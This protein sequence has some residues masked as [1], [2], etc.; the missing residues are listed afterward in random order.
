MIEIVEGVVPQS[1]DKSFVCKKSGKTLVIS[2]AQ[3]RPALSWATYHGGFR[4]QVSHI[5]LHALNSLPVQNAR[6]AAS[7][8]DLRG[9]VVGMMVR[10]D[11]GFHTITAVDGDLHA[12]VISTVDR[13]ALASVGDPVA[14]SDS[15]ELSVY[16]TAINI[17]LITNYH[18]TQE[19]MLE[20]ISIATE[21]KTR[22]IYELSLHGKS[23][24]LATGGETDCIAIATG[25][26]RRY[27]HCRKDS[28]WGELIGRASLEC[29]RKALTS[30]TPSG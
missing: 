28:R 16:P 11:I 3:P 26:E 14:V 21:A 17:I 24:Q 22:A 6:Q 25:I 8:L 19:A 12:S 27:T 10:N 7:R 2:F 4:S 29:M 15:Q 20:A 23:G 9:T 5:V 18:F 30:N 13:S 1:R